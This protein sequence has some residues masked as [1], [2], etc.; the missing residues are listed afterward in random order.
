MR[1][2]QFYK[3]VIVLLLLLNGGTLAFLWMNNNKEQQMGHMPPRPGRNHVDRMMSEKLNLTPDQENTFQLLKEEHHGQMVA[4]QHEESQ[5]HK[6]LFLLLKSSNIDTAARNEFF[7]KLAENDR[8]KEDVT[9]EH[10]VKLRLILT[11][12]QVGEF[13]KLVEEIASQILSHPRMGRG[14][15]PPH[16]DGPPPPPEER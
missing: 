4:I 12:D 10:F 11:P 16:P 14:G 2:E 6:D 8:E 9:F 3:I 7:R 5:L 1:N 15:P 13:D